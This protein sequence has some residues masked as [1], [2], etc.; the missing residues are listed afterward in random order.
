MAATS[1]ISRS[2]G[3][4]TTVTHAANLWSATTS[5]A[6][7]LPATSSHFEN[8]DGKQELCTGSGVYIPTIKLRQCHHK[9]GSE[10]KQLFH[11]LMEHFF[12]DEVLAKSVAFGSRSIPNGKEVLNPKIV[13]AIK[14]TE[15]TFHIRFNIKNKYKYKPC[16]S[17]RLSNE[18]F[19]T[20][21][22]IK[23]HIKLVIG[24]S[25][26]NV[27]FQIR[28]RGLDQISS[29]RSLIQSAEKPRIGSNCAGLIFGPVR[30]GIWNNIKN[31]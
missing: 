19:K 11:T 9:A 20:F 6:N 14:G 26:V 2:P 8:G 5:V 1:T 13:S 28:L 30:W 22:W 21:F 31:E 23:L 3:P 25:I 4:I 27:I 7:P 24:G 18:D 29:P 16:F 12:T 15:P 17:A 10:M